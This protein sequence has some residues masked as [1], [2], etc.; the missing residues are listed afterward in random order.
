MKSSPVRQPISLPDLHQAKTESRKL[1][2]VTCYDAS[3]A[4]AIDAAEVDLVLVGDSLGMVIQGHAST[5]PVTLKAMRYHTRCV[6][7]G[8]R[9][10]WLAADQIGVIAGLVESIQHAQRVVADLRARNRMCIARDDG[11]FDRGD[12]VCGVGNRSHA[13]GVPLF[14]ELSNTIY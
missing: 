14:L 6:A 2:M 10:A 4:R 7:R 5:L 11:G 9:Q 1:V 13:G 8:L 12:S 3:F